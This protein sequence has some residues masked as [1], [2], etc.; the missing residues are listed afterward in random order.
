MLTPSEIF[1]Q[2]WKNFCDI[3]KEH[4]SFKASG[5][6]KKKM[7]GIFK[8]HWI[9]IWKTKQFFTERDI[10]LF[11]S[12]LCMDQLG[13]G[14]VHRELPIDKMF[15]ENYNIKN[16]GRKNYIDIAIINPQKFK[17]GIELRK[18]TWDIFAEVKYISAGMFGGKYGVGRTI[19]GIKKD[20]EKLQNQFLKNRCEKGFVCVVND[21][22]ERV[23][24]GRDVKEW[25]TKYEP[26][27]VL[28]CQIKLQEKRG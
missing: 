22:G 10:A 12:K 27:R 9:R 5:Y 18:A 8:R 3:Y 14:W 26:I 1:E 20:C 6:D 17:N 13:Y 16:D 2:C 23:D 15:F 28:L 4:E 11:L 24:L 25:E 7:K 19:E 21:L